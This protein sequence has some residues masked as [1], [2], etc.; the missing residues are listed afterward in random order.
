M[1][2]AQGSQHLVLV[3]ADERIQ[4]RITLCGDFLQLGPA[5]R[6]LLAQAGASSSGARRAAG[7]LV[8]PP[9]L[10]LRGCKRRAQAGHVLD[11]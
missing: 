2:N 5:H 1:G 8:Q 3:G 11:G 4:R 9:D 7:A 6:Q 10:G